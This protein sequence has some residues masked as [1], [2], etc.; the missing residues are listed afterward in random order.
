VRRRLHSILV[1]V[2][3]FSMSFDV[4]TACGHLR[5]GCQVRPCRPTACMPIVVTAC[6]DWSAGCD[7]CSPPVVVLAPVQA[8]GGW[9]DGCELVAAAVP[10]GCCGEAV[11]AG[12]VVVEAPADV[13]V[14]AAPRV[15][16]DVEPTVA[17]AAEPVAAPAVAAGEPTLHVPPA[18]VAAVPELVAVEPK[19]VVEP[20]A[21]EQPVSEPQAEAEPAP[22]PAIEQPPV[23]EPPPAPEPRKIPNIFE[24]VEAAALE[25]SPAPAAIEPSPAEEPAVAEPAVAEPVVAEPAVEEPAVAEPAAEAPA[26]PP[27]PDAAEP[28]GAEPSADT[29]RTAPVE[30]RR[31]WI[32]AAGAHATVGSLVDVRG[33]RVEILKANGRTITVPIDRLSDFDR[34]YVS[35]AGLRLAAR[36]GGPASRDTAGL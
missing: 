21:A 36:R 15:E 23:A 10:L 1:G 13:A 4:A 6:A 3:T 18:A 32:D 22:E 19:S 12:M 7:P 34:D 9:V 16:V 30:P 20:A 2:L 11:E 24:E 14:E 25:S 31:R 5:R 17:P 28:S 29:A 33:D 8:W 26:A 27:K 35:E